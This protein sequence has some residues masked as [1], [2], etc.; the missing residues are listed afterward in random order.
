MLVRVEYGLRIDDGRSEAYWTAKE[1]LFPHCD[2]A[3]WGGCMPGSD[4]ELKEV[5]QECNAARDK[6]LHEHPP[7]VSR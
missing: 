2:D 7:K 6:W 1:A 3:I 4:E 5:C